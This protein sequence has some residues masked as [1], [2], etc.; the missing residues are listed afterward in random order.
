MP[1]ICVFFFFLQYRP[2]PVCGFSSNTPNCKAFDK[3]WWHAKIPLY[4]TRASI[5]FQWFFVRSSF[6][7]NFFFHSNLF[8]E[9]GGRSQKPNSQIVI[10]QIGNQQFFFDYFTD[11]PHRQIG[12]G[13]SKIRIMSRYGLSV[14]CMQSPHPFFFLKICLRDDWTHLQICFT[15][16][17]AYPFAVTAVAGHK[18]PGGTYLSKRT[19][20]WYITVNSIDLG[21][22][23]SFFGG[24][25]YL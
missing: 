15:T 1:E 8:L 11:L 19:L 17:T 22:L 3:V 2:G 21:C 4:R 7:L 13:Q 20:F 5:S 18:S 6:L 10:S 24:F 12:F 14:C 9:G 23:L 25:L 16:S